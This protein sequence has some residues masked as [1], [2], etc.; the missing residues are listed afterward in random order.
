MATFSDTEQL[1]AAA[2]A[3]ARIQIKT[4]SVSATSA[5][6]TYID[7]LVEL[8]K[9]THKDTGNKLYLELMRQVH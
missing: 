2:L 6:E 4:G 8:K 9:A 3:A 5:V 7:C 1:V